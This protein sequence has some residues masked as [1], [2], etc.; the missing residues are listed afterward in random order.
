MSP[1]Q[2]TKVSVEEIEKAFWKAAEEHPGPAFTRKEFSK[3]LGGTP[4]ARR[5]A[6]MDSEGIGPDGGFYL[7]RTKMYLKTLA[8]PWA[9]N[10][11]E[12]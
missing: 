6:N 10:R 1:T 11:V 5:F 12:L 7:G 4:S 9:L 8:V 2:K 3:F